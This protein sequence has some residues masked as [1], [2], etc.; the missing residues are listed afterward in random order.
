M[1]LSRSCKLS[2]NLHRRTEL[3]DLQTMAAQEGTKQRAVV[4]ANQT[5]KKVLDFLSSTPVVT[6]TAS[7]VLT[8]NDLNRVHLLISPIDSPPS[9][10]LTLPPAAECTGKSIS[11]SNIGVVGSKLTIRASNGEHIYGG[12]STD[13]SFSTLTLGNACGLTLVTDG[14]NW[15][16]SSGIAADAIVEAGGYADGMA[17]AWYRKLQSGMVWMGGTVN[18]N[19]AT[20]RRI[21]LP[22]NLKADDWPVVTLTPIWESTSG[23]PNVGYGHTSNTGFT[24]YSSSPA[25]VV[26]HA[27]GYW[28]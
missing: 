9:V 6:A 16:S 13:P 25:V 22:T 11:F 2:L 26:W 24:L 8:V 1:M 17:S 18:L 7:R 12:M 27:Y 21:S 3:S 10:E 14:Y 20:S 19:G 5:T 15:I 23:I 28:R 4:A